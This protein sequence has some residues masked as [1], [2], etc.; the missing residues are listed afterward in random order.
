VEEDVVA[1][2][3]DQP[4]TK[5]R[6]KKNHCLEATSTRFRNCPGSHR[7]PNRHPYHQ[8][9]PEFA[10]AGYHQRPSTSVAK[11]SQCR[12]SRPVGCH[13]K[14]NLTNKE[15]FN[16]CI[17]RLLLP[18]YFYELQKKEN[19]IS[20]TTKTLWAFSFSRVQTFTNYRTFTI[21]LASVSLSAASRSPLKHR[22]SLGNSF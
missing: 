12:R 18:F 1:E 19:A 17:S 22:T 20:F 2:A 16:Q 14:E 9:C 5:T 13:Q 21:L 7:R 4:T 8:L 15:P 3:S 11:D 10:R 6:T